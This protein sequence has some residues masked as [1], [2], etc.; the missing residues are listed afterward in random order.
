MEQTKNK[1]DESKHAITGKNVEY[2]VAFIAYQGRRNK[3]PPRLGCGAFAARL[4]EE[5]AYIT[6]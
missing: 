5:P 6:A 2:V 4:F 3:G 1:N